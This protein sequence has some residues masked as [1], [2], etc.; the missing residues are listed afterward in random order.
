MAQYLDPKKQH[1]GAI[2]NTALPATEEPVV[3]FFN[4]AGIQLPF[5]NRRC[6]SRPCTC[7]RKRIRLHCGIQAASIA[8][9]RGPENIWPGRIGLHA[10]I[11]LP[12]PKRSINEGLAEL[13]VG[14]DGIFKQGWPLLCPHSAQTAA[15][16]EAQTRGPCFL[17]IPV[18]KIEYSWRRASSALW[19][20]AFHS[21]APIM[22]SHGSLKTLEHEAD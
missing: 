14:A 12:E 8:V 4:I 13:R 18:R 15:L 19:N 11:K 5:H 2:R 6:A 20:L 1:T 7:G 10:E 22:R 9:L 16:R 3:P 17:C 21:C